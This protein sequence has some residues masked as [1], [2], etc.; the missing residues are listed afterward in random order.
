MSAAALGLV[1]FTACGS[2]GGHTFTRLSIS[3]GEVRESTYGTAFEILSHHR[4]LIVFEDRIGFRG[5]ADLDGFDRRSYSVPILVVNGDRNLND[6]I[7]VLRRLSAEE[8]SVIELWRASMVPPEYR[9]P[10][11]QGGVIWIRTR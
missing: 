10:G 11:W 7:T 9:R 3:P 1:A 5:G 4:E 6:P 8:I 2:G